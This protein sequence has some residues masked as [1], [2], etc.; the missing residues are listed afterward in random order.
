MPTFPDYLTLFIVTQAGQKVRTWMG[1][2]AN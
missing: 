2:P 1:K